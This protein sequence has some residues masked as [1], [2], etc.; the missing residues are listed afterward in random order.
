M[1]D[2]G[3]GYNVGRAFL[4]LTASFKGIVDS[5]ASQMPALGQQAGNI[6]GKA[7]ADAAK[8]E[9]GV[10]VGP[11]AATSAKQGDTSGGAFA[12][13]FKK[14]VDAALKSLPS[15]TI[16]A[17][18][19][20]TDRKIADLRAQLEGLSNTHIGVDIS[21]EEALTALATIRGELDELGAQSPDIQV[22][23]DT[24]TASA[25]LEEI[26][27]QV[28]ELNGDTA[29]VDVDVD[30]HGSAEK[31]SSDISGLTATVLAFGPALVPIG[32]ALAG[33]LGGVATVAGAGAGAL[34]TL[35]LAFSGVK[36][37]ISAMSAAQNSAGTDAVKSGQQQASAAQ[38]VQSAEASLANARATAAEQAITSAE[39][40]K[41][42]QQAVADAERAQAQQQQQS[43]E[44]IAAA[45][46][47]LADAQRNAARDQVQSAQQVASAQQNLAQ[48]EQ[49]V[50]D[51]R[52]SALRAVQT[53]ETD[54]TNAEQKSLQAEQALADARAQAARDLEDSA[55]KQVD[56]QQAAQQAVFDLTDAQNTLTTAQTSGADQLT[57]QKDTLAVAEAQQRLVEANE[58]AAR[59]AQ[60]NTAAQ[61]AGVDGSPGVVSAQQSVTDA[62]NTQTTAQQTLTDAITAQQ[63]Q[64]VTGAQQIA[65]A[66]LSVSNA[67]NDQANSAINAAESV[68]NAQKSLGDAQNTAA[69]QVV[70]SAE[71]VAKAQQG[72]SDALRSQQDQQRSSNF[73]ITQAQAALASAGQST[74]SMSTSTKN[75]AKALAGLTPAGASFARFLYG[76]K[77]QLTDL[78]RTA[79]AG[80]LPG[81]QS[82]IE[83]LLPE[84][85]LVNNL[86]GSLAK[87]MGNLAQD[88]GN[89]FKDPFWQNFFGYIAVTAGPIITTLGH[90]VG[91]IATG[92]AGLIENFAPL[93]KSIGD[94][95]LNLSGE[96]SRFGQNSGSNGFQTFLSYV[97]QT[98]PQVVKTIGSLVGA[99]GHIVAALSGSGVNSLSEFSLLAKGISDIPI[100]VLSALESV[101]GPIALS[102]YG[103][104]KVSSAFS[105]L[106]SAGKAI[107]GI[108]GKLGLYTAAQTEAA[109][110]GEAL[111]GAETEVDVAADA[112]PFGLIALAVAAV[113]AGIYEAYEHSAT[114]RDIV[115]EIGT[116]AVDAFDFVKAHIDLLVLAFGPL[117]AVPVLI[118]NNFGTI[119]S[120]FEG[121]WGDI[122]TGVNAFVDFFTSTIPN[123]ATTVLNFL[124]QN[125]PTILAILGGPL[126]LAV[127]EIVK[128]WGDIE[129]A[130]SSGYNWVANVFSKT[131]DAVEGV[132]TSPVSS[133]KTALDKVWSTIEG[134][135]SATK[136]WVV[137]TFK[138]LWDGVEGILTSPFSAAK[139]TIDGIWS[140]IES[141]A[142]TLWHDV[143]KAFGSGIA[144][145]LNVVLDFAHGINDALS[146]F[147]IPTIP[148]GTLTSAIKD[149]N[150]LV[151]AESGAVLPAS[152]V[153]SGFLTS[154][155]R[156]IVGEGN[157]A[158]PEYVVPTDPKHR[159][160]A[161]SLYSSLGGQLMDAGGIIG[162]IGSFFGDLTDPIGSVEKA[163]KAL[164]PN[165]PGKFFQDLASGIVDKIGSSALSAIGG[166]FSSLGGG[167]ATKIVIPGIGSGPAEP[168]TIPTSA[169][170]AMILAAF[171]YAGISPSA[172]NVADTNL[173]ITHESG[174]NP[175]A[176]NLSDINAKEGHPSQGLMQTIP[177]TFE[178][179]RDKRLPDIITNPLA[180]LVA[181][182]NYAT[183]RYGD[184]ADVPGVFAVAHGGSYVGYDGGGWLGTGIT[185]AFNAT[186]KPE[187]ILTSSQWDVISDL[188]A[189]QLSVAQSI[190]STRSVADVAGLGNDTLT[191]LRGIRAEVTAH[192]DYL[193]NLKT[194]LA[195]TQ[196]A[197]EQSNGH[198]AELT[199]IAAAVR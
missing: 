127:L 190:G 151:K 184:L 119:E 123:A 60:D 27:A 5:I 59:A 147:G 53:A 86:V 38:Q 10:G 186:G 37:A 166:L 129:G 126:G 76:L 170:Q 185:S 98:G 79:Q 68:A 118:V 164:I 188:A 109:G 153:G 20:E 9:A 102:L 77:P 97:E 142:T 116:V 90:I 78:Q 138:P 189:R 44:Q 176:I 115:K 14:R 88:A 120:F 8:R 49:T 72:V 143:G 110:A 178:G 199:S 64:V 106:N 89:A 34:G 12:D 15:V 30:D 135:F 125:W 144:G 40:V 32:A 95:L 152:N 155:I 159:G 180:N 31:V 55:N 163:A 13:S 63:K 198:E 132:L 168:G 66:T 174:W 33:S 82:G 84:L 141:G 23:S 85:P 75:L 7:F 173:I 26:Q 191:E 121:L 136:D 197:L 67:L 108:I 3:E 183:R 103:I 162:S 6:F 62:L 22:R 17:D 139:T 122:E 196:A 101:L 96:F 128:H 179:N 29:T 149:A 124:S 160:R 35:G 107:D 1:A 70:S 172:A 93:T 18:S 92:F 182:L 193:S 83:A 58:D 145:V 54:L 177:S 45:Q 43:I 111:A 134:A 87:A 169:R 161:L 114:F 74:D 16:D 167:D 156:A 117:I 39:S 56:T 192:T 137:N 28:D 57:I 112:N 19:S 69:Q 52:E 158:Y 2:E 165:I 36:G 25:K 195:G 51:D 154:G 113:A 65:A 131:W 133:A 105:T 50:A 41:N 48:V 175:T 47:S 100:P 150:N 99:L 104:S 21:A 148:T 73:S 80:L 194:Y 71:T 171:R 46:Q 94:A 42:A 4:E 146:V 181:G 91:N 140:G 81:V 157:P 11:D 187:A 61:K 24:A 130:F